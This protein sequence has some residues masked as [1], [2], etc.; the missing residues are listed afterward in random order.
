[1]AGLAATARRQRHRRGTRL[2][3]RVDLGPGY[4]TEVARVLI[5]KGFTKLGVRQVWAQTMAVN[6]A[7]RRVMEKAG[8]T[9]CGPFTCISMTHSQAPNT[10]R[11]S[12]NY[13]EVTGVP[14][15]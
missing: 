9:M 1:M 15:R 2:S 12:T 13:T 10:A 8:L 11:S 4:A 3:A 7:S 5:Q 14:S 6:I